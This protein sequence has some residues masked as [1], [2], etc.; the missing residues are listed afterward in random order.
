MKHYTFLLFLVTALVSHAKKPNFV[1]I[2]NDDMGY[3]DLGCFGAEKIKTPRVDQM[4]KEGRKFSSFYVASA[5]CSASR[6]A[7]LTGCYPMRVGVRGVFFPNRGSHG[8]EPRHFTIAE[9]LKSAGYKTLAAGKWHLGDEDDHQPGARGF[10]RVFIHGAGGIGQGYPGSCGDAPGNRYLNPTIRSDGTFVRTRGYCTD[11]F[12]GEAIRWMDEARKRDEPFFCYVPHNMPHVPLYC[13]DKF[14]GKS[15]HGLYA[16][17]MMEI[18]WSMGQLMDTLD[19]HGLAD[20]TIVIFTSDNGPWISYGNHAGVTPYREAKGTGFDGGTRSA[21]VMRMPGTIPAGAISHQ[22][23]C[24]V[25]LLPTLANL[26]GASFPSSPIDGVDVLPILSCDPTATNPHDYYPVST[27]RTFDGVV[28][29]DGKWKLHLP[30]SYRTLA[31]A[32]NDG[33][34][35]RYEQAHIDLSLFDMENDPYETTNVIDEHPEVAGQLQAYAESH[36]DKWWLEVQK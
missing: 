20:N 14:D 36:R 16:D 8:L 31:E 28:S 26:A 18:D 22:A 29:G 21:C 23:F 11:V 15:G 35:G 2:F 33:Q 19:E 17:V 34:P 3:A 25:D 12:F 13:S 9:L 32:G 5:V 6:A 30:H 7:L 1:I 27:G 10:D 4:A 24:S